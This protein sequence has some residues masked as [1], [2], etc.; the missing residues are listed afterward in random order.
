MRRAA[1]AERAITIV[2]E[3]DARKNDARAGVQN[4]LLTNKDK[5]R[6]PRKKTE[7]DKS[8][9]KKEFKFQCHRCRKYGHKAIECRTQYCA[10]GTGHEESGRH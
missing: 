10:V 5:R 1:I 4:A 2:E 8:N 7:D 6:N 9:N 3:N